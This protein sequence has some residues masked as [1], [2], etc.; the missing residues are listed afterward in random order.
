MAEFDFVEEYRQL[1]PASD[2]DTI[3]ARKTAF[4]TAKADAMKAS[5]RVVDLAHFAF[6]LPSRPDHDA[7]T[8]FLGVMRK[9]DTTFSLQRDAEEAA[10]IA[11]LVLKDRLASGFYG[12]TVAV[13][14]AA[15]A[16]KRPTVD[17]NGLSIAAR[18]ALHDIV[19]KRGTNTSPS[20]ITM[21]KVAGV[22]AILKSYATENSETTESEVFEAITADYT[23]QI[24]QVMASANAAI[25]NL[26][27]E[28]K[29]LDEEVDLLWW[30]LGQESFLL[31]RPL[32]SIPEA[33]RPIV[34]GADLAAMV[35][36]LPGPYGVYAVAKKALGPLAD[37][38]IKLSEA[39]KTVD[40]SFQNLIED[41]VEDYAIA[42]IHG[43]LTEVLLDSTSVVGAQFKRKT[44]LSFDGKLTGYEL[45]LQTYHEALLL[46]LEWF[47]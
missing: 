47:Q 7:D 42:P 44:G 2:R 26:W 16:G 17:D 24:K 19:R 5:G 22:G 28:K 33:A 27:A 21:A 23:S 20:K 46:K 38:Q 10:R 8:W 18:K 45:A 3:N 37:R 41:R 1:Q 40:S 34:I 6:R 13:Y 9:D 30:H 32:A 4:D 29:R 35:N 15:F 11:T 25:E 14:A 43:A 12:T 39:I 36:S 31:D